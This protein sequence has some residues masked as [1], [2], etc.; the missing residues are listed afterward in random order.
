M[1]VQDE[2]STLEPFFSTLQLWV[3]YVSQQK[4]ESECNSRSSIIYSDCTHTLGI[5]ETAE[6][7]WEAEIKPVYS[8]SAQIRGPSSSTLP[9]GSA[10]HS[11]LPNLSF[12]G[13]ECSSG[14]D[15]PLCC[16]LAVRALRGSVSQEDR[17]FAPAFYREV[18]REAKTD[19][20]GTTADVKIN[21]GLLFHPEEVRDSQDNHCSY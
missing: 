12:Y 16:S 6:L 5:Q 21:E 2:T 14:S 11:A 7:R 18:E 15:S 4:E 1:N 13:Q 17:C 20:E 9:W 19:S 3:V 10:S 8:S